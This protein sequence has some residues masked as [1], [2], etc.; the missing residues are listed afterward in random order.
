[1]DKPKHIIHSMALDMKIPEHG[2][3]QILEFMPSYMAGNKGY[4]QLHGI[5]MNTQVII[6]YLEET[7]NEP[8][9][10]IGYGDEDIPLSML[11]YSYGHDI[12]ACGHGIIYPRRNTDNEA[13]G[14]SIVMT[15]ADLQFAR[16]H[17]EFTFVSADQQ[18]LLTQENK[19]AQACVIAEDRTL[20]QFYVPTHLSTTTYDSGLAERIVKDIGPAEYYVVK[21]VDQSQGNGVRIIPADDMNKTLHHML[22]N[23]RHYK[24]E[25]AGRDFWK[26]DISPVMVVQPYIPSRP[27]KYKN[28][29]YDGTLRTFVTMYRSIDSTSWEVE[30]HDGY[31]KLP[32]TPLKRGKA[33]LEQLVSHSPNRFESNGKKDKKFSNRRM[34]SAPMT[35]A[36]CKEIFPQI[37]EFCE[38]L[39]VVVESKSLY[40]RTWRNL[41][42]RSA[43]R[44]ATGISM[45]LNGE[46]YPGNINNPLPLNRNAFPSKVYNR[47]KQL[48]L[49]GEFGNAAENYVRALMKP[50]LS[51]Y[52]TDTQYYYGSQYYVPWGFLMKLEDDRKFQHQMKE[53]LQ[54]AHRPT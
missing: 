7:L 41:T 54:Q 10:E 29:D 12:A 36:L 14:G 25:K 26:T 51:G 42:H 35:L 5:D 43:A 17:P 27:V 40:Q 52:F 16:S 28:H 18:M 45:A 46:Y 8:T 2:P 50:G 20:R 34:D 31:W 22:V 32:A 38:R 33:Q 44:Q 23:S 24:K 19:A 48:C 53:R 47:I 30:I 21:P 49:K 37:H 39:P 13:G 6:P 9:E 15:R 1:M 3:I 11:G 4:H